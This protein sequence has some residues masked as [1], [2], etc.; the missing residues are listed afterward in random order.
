M[1]ARAQVFRNLEAATAW[2]VV[3][4]EDRDSLDLLEAFA[5]ADDHLLVVD[6]PDIPEFVVIRLVGLAERF[7]QGLPCEIP[8]DVEGK[9]PGEGVPTGSSDMQRNTRDEAH[10]VTE[11]VLAPE[12]CGMIDRDGRVTV[13]H[14]FLGV[15]AIQNRRFRIAG[16]AVLGDD[17]FISGRF[18]EMALPERICVRCCQCFV[19]FYGRIGISKD[20]C[21]KLRFRQEA[22]V[23]RGRG[24]GQG[25]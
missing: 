21:F 24:A 4:K 1:L 18:A 12:T 8:L 3:G 22:E 15:V 7:P 2:S 11:L 17:G 19:P 20:R 25:A 10:T 14:A 16:S 6:H 5:E 23:P 9:R 13:R